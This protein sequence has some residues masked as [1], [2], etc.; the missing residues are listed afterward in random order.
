VE[1]KNRDSR[2][3]GNDELKTH[4]APKT[5]NRKLNDE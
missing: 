5:Q 3:T 4:K 2:D 1:I